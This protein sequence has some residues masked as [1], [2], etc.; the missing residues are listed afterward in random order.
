MFFFSI[1]FAYPGGPDECLR[2]CVPKVAQINENRALANTRKPRYPHLR[3][4]AGERKKS[5]ASTLLLLKCRSRLR[6]RA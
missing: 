2:A 6:P 3:I 5:F 4:V 1:R